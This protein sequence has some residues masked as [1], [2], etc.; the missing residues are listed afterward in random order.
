MILCLIGVLSSC[1]TYGRKD[2][3][4]V[5]NYKSDICQILHYASL[6]GSSHNSQPWKVEVYKE[7]SILVFPDSARI[8]SVVDH[9]GR[10][11]FISLG[12]FIENLDIASGAFGYNTSIELHNTG[13]V[14]NN[15]VAIKQSDLEQ[16]MQH[17]SHNL[18]SPLP[19]SLRRP[20]ESFTVFR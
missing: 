1:S 8:L 3:L 17:D 20:V 5:G 9:D 2:T 13:K 19:V 11:L 12:A 15:P 10:E 14:N 6:A 4:S 7:D 16:L 18:H